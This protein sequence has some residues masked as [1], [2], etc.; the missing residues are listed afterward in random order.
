MLTHTHTGQTSRPTKYL[1]APPVRREHNRK[2]QHMS[3]VFPATY[4][5]RILC[6]YNLCYTLPVRRSRRTRLVAGLC[7]CAREK[8]ARTLQ[9]R[10]SIVRS[11]VCGVCTIRMVLH[12]DTTTYRVACACVCVSAATSEPSRV[13]QSPAGDR[14]AGQICANATFI[15]I[16]DPAVFSTTFHMSQ[17]STDRDVLAYTHTHTH[18]FHSVELFITYRL[19]YPPRHK[20][21]CVCVCARH[22]YVFMDHIV[23]GTVREGS[24]SFVVCTDSERFL[25]L[26][27]LNVIVSSVLFCTHTHTNASKRSNNGP[28]REHTRL[29]P[30]VTATYLPD[31]M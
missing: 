12:T 31:F 16:F 21:M 15:F 8:P 5:Q 13:T 14:P 1:T 11:A 4:R 2:H 25:L 9:R 29:D 23:H 20:T 6:L 27:L 17:Q 26:L 3:R 7:V 24:G 22:I 19:V 30:A 28:S 10:R 18:A